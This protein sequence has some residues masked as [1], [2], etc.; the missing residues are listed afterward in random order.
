[1]GIIT[2]KTVRLRVTNQDPYS[3][4]LLDPDPVPHSPIHDTDPDPDNKFF[5]IN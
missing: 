3:F 5:P 2:K 4:E 1:M